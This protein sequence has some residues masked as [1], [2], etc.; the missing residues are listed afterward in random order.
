VGKSAEFEKAATLAWFGIR[1]QEGNT[2]EGR[3]GMRRKATARSLYICCA[4]C[5]VAIGVKATAQT[6]VLEGCLGTSTVCTEAFAGDVVDMGCVPPKLY[7]IFHGRVSW[8]ALT[9]MG[10]ISIE[11]NA[12]RSAAT[13]FPLYV[14]VIRAPG[15][16]V[17]FCEVP[18]AVVMTAF[19]SERCDG[20]EV[21]G[22]LDLG[23]VLMEGEQ[24]A[25]RLLFLQGMGLSTRSPDFGCIRVKS[26]STSMA[27][28]RSSWGVV[29]CVYKD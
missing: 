10:P 19:G 7:K 6:V 29:K 11:I 3:S 2:V 25:V 21:F 15:P 27:M 13:Q 8:Q 16:G 17:S 20:W 9:Y 28:E 23:G 18:G 14:E 1:L 22:P 24:Y 5:L 12:K 4:C 26:N